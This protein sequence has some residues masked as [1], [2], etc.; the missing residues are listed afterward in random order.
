MT[1]I[2]SCDITAVAIVS[3]AVMTPREDCDFRE[4]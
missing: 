4:E 1:K 3:I 2:E